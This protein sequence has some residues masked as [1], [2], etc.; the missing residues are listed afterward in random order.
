MDRHK[1]EFC[2]TLTDSLT[3]FM[4]LYDRTI[5]IKNALS[6]V[7][8]N[9]SVGL[10]VIERRWQKT[11]EENYRIWSKTRCRA[12]I[13]LDNTAFAEGDTYLKLRQ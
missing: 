1:T 13:R 12:K 11:L 8:M 4:T 10:C 9:F 5:T 7:K 3:R 2:F 6:L